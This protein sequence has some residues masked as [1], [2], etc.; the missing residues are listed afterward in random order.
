ML[1]KPLQAHT[2]RTQATDFSG[3]Q[4]KAGSKTGPMLQ[5]ETAINFMDT[6]SILAADTGIFYETGSAVL[7]SGLKEQQ[8]ILDWM[9]DAHEV[10]LDF[11]DKD[12]SVATCMTSKG[13][14]VSEDKLAEVIDGLTD[15][16][17][18]IPVPEHIRKN[19]EKKVEEE[20][21][22]GVEQDLEEPEENQRAPEVFVLPD[23][24]KE[25]GKLVEYRRLGKLRDYLE[26][27]MEEMKKIQTEMSEH[28]WSPAA[29][30]L[31]QAGDN[32]C[33]LSKTLA[34][35]PPQDGP[36]KVGMMNAQLSLHDIAEALK[37]ADTVLAGVAE[38]RKSGGVAEL[39]EG[40]EAVRR[41]LLQALDRG[42]F[43]YLWQAVELPE[44]VCKWE[45]QALLHK[46]MDKAYTEMKA[47]C[48]KVVR[49][50]EKTRDAYLKD[51]RSELKG[52]QEEEVA[53]SEL[54]KDTDGAD[55]MSAKIRDAARALVPVCVEL[56][57]ALSEAAATNDDTTLK[58]L[59]KATADL[60]NM[61]AALHNAAIISGVADA[62]E[63]TRLGEPLRALAKKALDTVATEVGKARD[64]LEGHLKPGFFTMKE[65]HL[66]RHSRTTFAM[67]LKNA[68]GR[69]K[70]VKQAMEKS[71][72][73]LKQ[74]EKVEE[75]VAHVLLHVLRH[76]WTLK[77]AGRQW[78]N[79]KDMASALG[80]LAVKGWRAAQ[81]GTA[82]G[83]NPA[84]PSDFHWQIRGVV[85]SPLGMML[86]IHRA[87]EDLAEAS[88]AASEKKP[89][90]KRELRDRGNILTPDQRRETLHQY[91]EAKL[92]GLDKKRVAAEQQAETLGRVME[93]TERELG[94]MQKTFLMRQHQN[95]IGVIRTLCRASAKRCRDAMAEMSREMEQLVNPGGNSGIPASALRGKK[96]YKHAQG[97]IM[98][99]L[100]ATDAAMKKLSAEVAEI[101]HK[102]INLFSKDAK[103]VKYVAGVLHASKAQ[104]PED[105]SEE[106][107]AHLLSLFD[108]VVDELGDVFKTEKDPEGKAFIDRVRRE[109]VLLEMKANLAAET[110]EKA[111]A[112]L[113][114]WVQKMTKKSS[115]AVS[116]AF[117]KRMVQTLFGQTA[118]SLLGG[119]FH[120]AKILG[121][122][123]R[124]AKE[125]DRFVTDRGRLERART[126]TQ[127]VRAADLDAVENRL[128][129]GIVEQTVS[130]FTPSAVKTV[131]KG[132]FVVDKIRQEGFRK[133]LKD[134]CGGLPGDIVIESGIQSIVSTGVAGVNALH[135]AAETRAEG[136]AG[137]AERIPVG[138][139]RPTEAN[140][141]AEPQV[142]SRGRR[143]TQPAM[144]QA[145][146]DARAVQPPVTGSPAVAEAAAEDD[147][148]VDAS[149][150]SPA[151]STD[152][153]EFT[154]TEKEYNDTQ[155]G[156]DARNKADYRKFIENDIQKIIDK[157]P[158]ARGKISSPY[159]Y[160][161]TIIKGP[162]DVVGRARIIDIY[163]GNVPFNAEVL[164]HGSTGDKDSTETYQEFRRELFGQKGYKSVRTVPH[165]VV[166]ITDAQ[167][168]LDIR[169]NPVIKHSAAKLRER[170]PNHLREM[171]TRAPEM[172]TLYRNIFQLGFKRALVS[173]NSHLSAAEKTAIRTFLN[174]DSSHV[175]T[176]K[177]NGKPVL[178]VIALEVPGDNPGEKKL[179]I[180]DYDGKLLCTSAGTVSNGNSFS[181]GADLQ[182]YIAQHMTQGASED[183]AKVSTRT[184]TIEN[185]GDNYDTKLVENY[186]T[187]QNDEFY[188][189]VADPNK[190]DKSRLF[191]KLDKI[192]DNLSFM[193]GMSGAP[194]TTPQGMLASAAVTIG[195]GIIKYTIDSDATERRNITI[196]TAIDTT[197]GLLTDG[198]GGR[199][200]G[201]IGKKNKFVGDGM[202]FSN[203]SGI[204]T[205]KVGEKINEE[206]TKLAKILGVEVKSKQNDAIS[207]PKEEQAL[208][209][210]NHLSATPGAG[211]RVLTPST[212]WRQALSDVRKGLLQDNKTNTLSTETIRFL[213]SVGV[214]IKK[215][216]NR[217]GS[218]ES[219]RRAT[220][221]GVTDYSRVE[222]DSDG[223]N[224]ILNEADKAYKKF[225]K[226]QL[227]ERIVN[228]LEELEKITANGGKI[229][230]PYQLLKDL[231]EAGIDIDDYLSGN[232]L[233]NDNNPDT[234]YVVR[235]EHS[236]L[237]QSRLKKL[238]FM[239]KAEKLDESD[240]EGAVDLVREIRDSMGENEKV[241]IPDKVIRMLKTPTT[242]AR[243]YILTNGDE[244]PAKAAATQKGHA[245]PTN[246]RF[247]SDY[248][249]NKGHLN[250]LI[251]KYRGYSIPNQQAAHTYLTKRID[252]ITAENNGIG[253]DVQ[254]YTF[255]E[256]FEN[257]LKKEG[258]FDLKT[259]LEDHGKYSMAK[260]CWL[261][262]KNQ[263]DDLAKE[264][265]VTLPA[266]ERANIDAKS[267]ATQLTANHQALERKW[268]NVGQELDALIAS[269]GEG[270]LT[271][272]T[273]NFLR[274]QGMD[275]NG[276]LKK[277][278]TPDEDDNNNSKVDSRGAS[279]IKKDIEQ[280]K[281]RQ[282]IPATLKQLNS[283][284]ERL[285]K[286]KRLNL[287]ESIRN[288]LK[289]SPAIDDND[290]YMEDIKTTPVSKAELNWMYWALK[291]EADLPADSTPEQAAAF[292]QELENAM[293]TG[294]TMALPPHLIN[295]LKAHGVKVD[296]FVKEHGNTTL[297]EEY[298]ARKGTPGNLDTR[299]IEIS[300]E[301]VTEL[302]GKLPIPQ[303]P[304]A[305]TADEQPEN[306]TPVTAA[307]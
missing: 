226:A 8:K 243:I 307:T 87:M 62:A 203:D 166:P 239:V 213:E 275:I 110:P 37:K 260:G 31:K 39:S 91:Q 199:V 77:K 7:F 257:A 227:Q 10:T 249:L 25:R 304:L 81:T 124:I 6:L 76:E 85:S 180:M 294:D 117:A 4:G 15:A 50:L 60:R 20:P 220:V 29:P 161:S 165:D 45:E 235:Y 194:K 219:R 169:K 135:K 109:G 246:H 154:M 104:I 79:A 54:A 102:Q 35:F 95:S 41:E 48:Q 28:K 138:N 185:T 251:E 241:S 40:P 97:A 140:R 132:G 187:A 200:L 80:H 92:A 130:L 136:K 232:A 223:V 253:D 18:D 107:R 178:D 179:L 264:L 126:P 302:R 24:R 75:G 103:L 51:V 59:K 55:P 272:G 231:R 156:M 277:N 122:G 282:K 244:T 123:Y 86:N 271:S 116:G 2:D 182:T 72:N 283:L 93:M 252:D 152:A 211:S 288:I 208:A 38:H 298:A 268:R 292:M 234:K 158:E 3:P 237:D 127:F 149:Q 53:L 248:T 299:D 284:M 9:Q 100:R 111:A 68:D 121:F 181:P 33:E 217:Y 49:A 66:S 258:V 70:I 112:H 32:L 46:G 26:V 131:V 42:R 218:V 14:P 204:T 157:H 101:T 197:A 164:W 22:F 153:S 229:Q 290:I 293:G 148:L 163:T 67:A 188:H 228:K 119:M 193:I 269:G 63:K 195:K 99:C 88:M 11:R 216:L 162:P 206:T 306:E 256:K 89:Q 186:L 254:I 144:E 108:R 176:L 196:Q 133:V 167:R 191:K 184:V 233:D 171:R 120:G 266:E 174:G 224:D 23:L 273:I 84:Q 90:V 303:E 106:E 52:L 129:Y 83:L 245:N 30:S 64:E 214:D 267:T 285:D 289:S 114:G 278:G 280:F 71:S 82:H 1:T 230:I 279:A 276:S 215:L 137:E 105:A 189:V 113:E 94:D 212:L 43:P 151:D 168:N 125:I 69:V 57:N 270:N 221:N 177:Y 242:N 36:Q 128:V 58:D 259:Y 13:V 281:R 27:D 44:E 296:D 301:R 238:R 263:M 262:S 21:L 160:V 142:H 210:E 172:A 141:I 115:G 261:L 190:E 5:P 145:A 96:D 12:A 236:I 56:G 146:S 192:A 147:A 202:K 175:M 201:K 159:S 209:T 207:A 34:A 155:I 287:P 98:K 65:K 47:D 17:D 19:Q 305:R 134:T 74:E 198:L 170:W 240:M 205:Q 297:A 143:S 173:P 295:R 265:Y 78:D 247:V 150:N 118:K 139:N 274:A 255:P 61:S 73:A 250:S 222:F 183:A 225:E 286:H 300:K 291:A 16:V